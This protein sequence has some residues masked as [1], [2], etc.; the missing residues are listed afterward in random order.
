MH[1]ATQTALA[2]ALLDPERAVP[3]AVT[4]H[5]ARVPARRF[6]VYRNNVTASLVKALRARFPVIE[7]LVGEEFFAAMATVFVRAQPPRSPILSLYGDEFP[8][9]IERFPP[10][11]EL[12]YAGDVARLEAARTRAYHAAD[13]VPLDAQ[14]L[15]TIDAAA[16]PDLSFALH[17]SLQLVR[18]RH[19]IVS[20]WAMNSGERPLQAIETDAA[21]DALVARPALTVSVR[22]L[23]PG[24]AAFLAA[25]A[26]RATLARAAQ[27][28][29]ADSADFDLTANLAGLFGTGLVT[30]CRLP[31]RT[32]DATP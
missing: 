14:A 27:A 19:A 18:S 21:E 13:A 5:T 3:A 15:A 31:T 12:A 30:A 29:L 10:M 17:P 16:V 1:A 6:A 8:D 4:A 9:F 25:L 20:I 26:G 11:A 24:G 28:A 2:A 32:E 23:P 22:S 7:K